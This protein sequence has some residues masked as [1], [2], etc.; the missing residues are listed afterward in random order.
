MSDERWL[1]WPDTHFPKEDKRKVSIML[2]VLEEWKPT[3]LSFLGDLDDMDGPS[4]FSKGTKSEVE[5]SVL[6][7]SSK[8]KNF[9]HKVREILPDSEID[10]F[11]G[12]HEERWNAYIDTSAPAAA[13][14]IT[15]DDLYDLS[16]LGINWW[17]YSNEPVKIFGDYHIHHGLS[18]SRH[19]GQSAM[20][21]HET[22]GVSGFSGHTHRLGLFT[23]TDMKGIHEWYECGHLVDVKQMDYV[24]TPNWQPGFAIAHISGNKV[25]PRLVKFV[26]NKCEV[27]GRIFE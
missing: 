17:N 4:R 3:R 15:F 7:S 5:N 14:L 22:F 25:L 13:D 24:V 16:N 8:V 26:G 10:Y 9:L 12:N 21:E 27:D 1:L 11:M 20:K 2:K 18:I 6:Y 23:K 19:S